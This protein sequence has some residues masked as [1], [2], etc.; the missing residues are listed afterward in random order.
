M[1][2]SSLFPELE[3][4]VRDAL[5]KDHAVIDLLA[6]RLL[7]SSRHLTQQLVACDMVSQ[8]HIY[9]AMSAQAKIRAIEWT[10]DQLAGLKRELE[11]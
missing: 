9:S 8:A 5:R 6:N 1:I 2:Q 10:L 3:D 7:D 11:Q 4:D